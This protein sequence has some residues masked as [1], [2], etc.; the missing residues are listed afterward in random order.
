L[1]APPD[2]AKPLAVEPEFTHVVA[3]GVSCRVTYQLRTYFRSGISYPFDWWI[4]PFDGLTRYVASLDPDRIFRADALVEQVADGHV[5]AIVSREF[6]ISLFHD[7][8]RVAVGAPMRVVS[9]DWRDHVDAARALHR[10]RLDRI[11]AL[12]DARNRILF[13]RHRPDDARDVRRTQDTVDALWAALVGRWRRARV[14]LLLVNFP[15]VARPDDDVMTATI[16]E[17]PGP[18]SEAW[19]GDDRA[20]ASALAALGIPPARTDD[21]TFVPP[22]PGE[23][24]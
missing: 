19:R 22:S 20:W 17:E 21:A 15:D 8:P 4:S 6:G 3:L 13:V 23:T 2:G 18:G 24:D 14:G 11:L 9:P 1:S 10:R 5:Q 7:F 12:D 16:G